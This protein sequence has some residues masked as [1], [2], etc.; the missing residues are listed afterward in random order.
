MVSGYSKFLSLVVLATTL[1]A[2]STSN[3][4][5]AMGSKG[6]ASKSFAKRHQSREYQEAKV[7]EQKTEVGIQEAKPTD[8]KILTSPATVQTAAIATDDAADQKVEQDAAIAVAQTTNENANEIP[9]G[10]EFIGNHEI[11]PAFGFNSITSSSSNMYML[12]NSAANSTYESRLFPSTPELTTDTKQTNSIGSKISA[13]ETEPKESKHHWVLYFAFAQAFIA[14]LLG[15]KQVF[16]MLD[17][18][19]DAGNKAISMSYATMGILSIHA[20]LLIAAAKSF[21]S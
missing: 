17:T 6:R 14:L 4:K 19:S 15:L 16:G 2:C 7:K 13:K 3:H 12:K 21:F 9:I 18:P 20:L 10:Q 8:I 1:A 5:G 11:D